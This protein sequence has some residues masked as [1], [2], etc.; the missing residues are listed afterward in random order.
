MR[1]RLFRRSGSRSG[2][3]GYRAATRP[4]QA[5]PWCRHYSHHRHSTQAA[6]S[7]LRAA[8]CGRRSFRSRHG[9]A[10]M[11]TS[12]RSTLPGQP[13]ETAA[14]LCPR[15][16]VCPTHKMSREGS[17]LWVLPAVPWLGAFHV[18]HLKGSFGLG[19][20][21]AGAGGGRR[22]AFF[23]YL[24]KELRHVLY[25][26]GTWLRITGVCAFEHE[27]STVK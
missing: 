18:S 22:E 24:K 9:D 10:G 5:G 16:P 21:R 19:V 14:L 25:Q 6:R 8:G 15:A 13:D 23:R 26:D 12:D 27:E 1:T 2:L 17:C 4:R 7:N 3:P 11:L 20:R